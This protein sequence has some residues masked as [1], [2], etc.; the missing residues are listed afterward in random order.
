MNKIELSFVSANCLAYGT[1][2][3]STETWK[4]LSVKTSFSTGGFES[5]NALTKAQ[6][7]TI[8]EAK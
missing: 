2:F 8:I 4:L 1:W 5:A 6:S 7:M 3:D